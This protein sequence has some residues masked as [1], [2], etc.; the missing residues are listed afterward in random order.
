MS[1]QIIA[2]KQKILL[3]GRY[4][5]GEEID[6]LVR[7]AV[8]EAVLDHKRAGN[9]VAGW[10]DGKVVI[11]QPEDIDLSVFDDPAESTKSPK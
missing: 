10:K 4:L 9:P 7:Q 8:R 11:V 6:G 3:G 1:N 2:N 5:T